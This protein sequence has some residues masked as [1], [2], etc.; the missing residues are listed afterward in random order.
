MPNDAIAP[1]AAHL[2]P[3]SLKLFIHVLDKGTIAAAAAHAH[4]A[5]AAISKRISDLEQ[6]LQV[7][8][9]LRT[10]KGIQPTPA[11]LALATLARRA[12]YELDAVAI[13]MREHVSGLRGYIRVHANISAITQFLPQDIQSF[14]KLYPNVH[15]DLE[16]KITPKIL[17]S[18]GE[19]EADIGIFSDTWRDDSVEVFDY[20]A[21]SLALIVPADHVLQEHPEF[22]FVDALE[23]DFIGLHRGSAINRLLSTAA[24]MANRTLKLK[25]QVTSFDA[26][27]FMVSSGLG[28]GVL[29]LDLAQRYFPMFDIRIIPLTEPWAKRKIQIAVRAFDALPTVTKHFV[30]HLLGRPHLLGVHS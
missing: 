17:K 6:Q 15:I 26:L 19:N 21:D 16:E 28:V 13:Q 29:P 11:G 20:R 9:L 5:P 1:A 12:L 14:L 10:N 18:V 4:I 2:D 22:R 27:C 3:T 30:N 23:H 7:P 24:D 25:V 8:L